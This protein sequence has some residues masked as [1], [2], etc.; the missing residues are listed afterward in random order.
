MH[1]KIFEFGDYC[2]EQ[3]SGC[4]MGTPAACIYA[5]IYYAYHDRNT[6]LPKHK[7]N[8]PFFQ[9]FIDNM[10]S[11]WTTSDNLSAWK[12]FKENPPFSILEWE[13]E[14]RTTSV[15]FLDLTIFINK[16]HKINNRTYQKAMNHYLYIPPTSSH[17]L[18]VIHGMIYVMLRK[19]DKKNSHRKHYMKTTVI[20]FRRMSACG[21]YTAL[22]QRIFNDASAQIE[23]KCPSQTQERKVNPNNGRNQVFIHT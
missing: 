13:V 11:I 19:Y 1:N 17:P 2:F 4:A 9:R 16:D 15:N 7:K 20:L 8:L 18:I 21:W 6:L 14:E 10:F 3:L 23:T 5:P 12:K 22:L